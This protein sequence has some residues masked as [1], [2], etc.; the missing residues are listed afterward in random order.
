VNDARKAPLARSETVL[1]IEPAPHCWV[2]P[3]YDVLQ[4]GPSKL[5][6]EFR[7]VAKG[8]GLVHMLSL[9]WSRHRGAC[10]V[11]GFLS[12]LQRDIRLVIDNEFPGQAPMATANLGALEWKGV[13]GH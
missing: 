10:T 5:V 4:S 11:L 12:V 2:S 1:W 7:R 6:I 8:Q 13:V 3:T 9:T